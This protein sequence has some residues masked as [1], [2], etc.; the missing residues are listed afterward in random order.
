MWGEKS[1]DVFIGDINN[2]YEKLVYWRKNV[3]KLPSGSSGKNFIK[4]CTRLI[5]SWT[6]KSAIRPI[7]LK[8]LMTMPAL[9]LKKPSKSSKSKDHVEALKR[10]L[11]LWLKGDINELVL[12]CETIQNRMKTSVRS[13]SI[14]AVSKQFASL[15][16]TGKVN[17]AVKLITNNMDG[18]ILPLNDETMTLLSSKHPDE[19]ECNPDSI[20]DIQAPQ[21][22]PVVYEQITAESVLTAAL[23]TRGGAGPSGMDADGWRHIL[24][25][26]IYGGAADDL[27]REFA[28]MVKLLCTEEVVIDQSNNSP[29]SSIEAF[30]ACRLIPLDK[31]PGLRPI[32]VGEVL[33]RIAGKIVMSLIKTDVQDAVGSLQLCAGQAGGCDAAIH[34]MRT[35]YEDDA[36]DAVLLIDAANAFN[37]MNRQSMLLNIGRLCPIVYTYAFNCYATHARLFVTGGQELKSRE[38]TTQGDP[39]AMAFY[40]LGLLPFTTMIAQSSQPSTQHHSQVAYADDLIGGGKL[41]QIRKWFDEILKHGPMF[42]Y[43][44]EPT[45]SWLIVKDENH[46]EAEKCFEGAGVNITVRGQKHLG[47]VIGKTEY[48]HEFVSSLVDKWVE[49][50]SILSQIA[51]TEPHAAYTAFTTCLRHHYVR[52]I[53]WI[54]NILE[55][56]EE[57]IRYY[58]IP[59]LTEGRQCTEDERAILTL[60]VRLGGMGIVNPVTMSD[61]EHDASVK[62]TS[63]LSKAIV[64]QRV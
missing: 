37:S 42:G 7:A 49:Q 51:S 30:L 11:E 48:K 46:Q 62:A 45:K 38:G 12:E 16:K 63:L 55:P 35:I 14:D 64:E 53:P 58:L 22:H 39:P 3:F 24:A 18:G 25:S 23:N 40:A 34:A 2:A 47:A 50:V 28:N 10:R 1:A 29:T 8:C 27:R 15:M 59:A 20:T 26:R 44:A 31:N 5:I 6:S 33:R 61:G 32:G 56:L 21:V 41:R 4:E 57:A 9:L 60:P 19:A 17:A 52:T 43:N 13:T 54:S 36:T